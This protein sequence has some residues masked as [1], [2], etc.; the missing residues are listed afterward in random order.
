LIRDGSRALRWLPLVLLAALVGF[1]WW[2]HAAV[3]GVIRERL[4]HALTTLVQSDVNALRLWI[5][6]EL[7]AARAVVRVAAVR[8]AAVAVAGSAPGAD[9]PALLAAPDA[10]RL[11]DAMAGPVAALSLTGWALVGDDD[12]VLACSHDEHVGYRAL[13]EQTDVFARARQ[14]DAAFGRPYPA[15]VA[16]P[17]PGAPTV[18]VAAPVRD[19]SGA[20]VAV[21]G[22]RL[23]PGNGFGRVLQVAR[24]PVAGETFAF[25]AQGR[26]LSEPAYTAQLRALG[27]LAG[28]REASAALGLVLRDPGVDLVDG[29]RPARPRDEQPLTH[30]VQEAVAG[31][32]GAD[33]DGYRDVR[34]VEVV[35]AWD[36]LP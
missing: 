4:A 14:G 30:M 9:R 36:W 7:V 17:Q 6:G 8:S 25:D 13:S 16:A 28:G 19:E 21:L 18:F 23:D 3:Q 31:H 11:R 20:I 12:R 10:A 29:G 22:L 5:D 26:L 24:P 34:G 33:V 27:L 32:S 2:T 35:G 1:A 15:L